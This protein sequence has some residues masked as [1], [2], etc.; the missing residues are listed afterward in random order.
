MLQFPDPRRRSL[1]NACVLPSRPCL[2]EKKK[3]LPRA[4]KLAER[5]SG[6]KGVLVRATQKAIR[7]GGVTERGDANN[8]NTHP[9]TPVLRP[10][11]QTRAGDGGRGGGK[12]SGGATPG[13]PCFRKAFQGQ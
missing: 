4:E 7:A 13:K 11:G 10:N 2:S 5:K 3:A 9:T 1:P 12:G 6:E 8:L